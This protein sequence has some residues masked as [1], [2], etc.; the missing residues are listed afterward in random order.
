MNSIDELLKFK[1]FE[2]KRFDLDYD[3]DGL[4]YKVNDFD[5]QS[6]LG[7]TSNS[8]RWAIAHKFS[9]DS[10]NTKVIKIEIQVGRTGALTMAQS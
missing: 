10:A 1:S 4:V 6:R 8:P 2:A 9:A 7:F 3:L 5:L